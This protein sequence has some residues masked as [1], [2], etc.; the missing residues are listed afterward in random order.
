MH[1]LMFGKVP[2]IQGGVAG[3]TWLACQDIAKAGHSIDVLTNANAMPI[4]FRQMFVLDDEV[5]LQA[6]RERLNLQ[7]ITKVPP[8]SYIPWAPPYF[9]QFMSY[10]LNAVDR[11]RPDVIVGWYL[12]PYGMVA[13]VIGQ[14]FDIPV[15]LRHAGSDIG[16]MRNLGGLKTFYDWALSNAAKVTTGR[17][18]Q[19]MEMLKAAGVREDAIIR[20]R[21]RRLCDSFSEFHEGFDMESALSHSEDW[22][23]RYQLESETLR[24][25]IEWN[26]ASYGNNAPSIGTYGKIAEVKGTYHL[27][28][29]LELLVR[30]GEK[31]SYRGIWSATPAR[32]QHALR[33][34]F[35]KNSLKG[36]I[37][38]LPPLVP[39]RIPAF[40]R[41]CSAVAFL[42]NRF[43]IQI[44][45]PKVPREVLACKRPLL[46]SREIFDKVHFRDQL[47]EE[48]NVMLVDDPH[49]VDVMADQ[50]SRLLNSTELLNCLGHHA[51]ALSR[52]LEARA[53]RVDPIVEVIEAVGDYEH[54]TKAFG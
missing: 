15:I 16:R 11:K 26:R 22:F 19:V 43:P 46:L 1:V 5:R 4:G 30:R 39:W 31:F 18:P 48:K 33:Y 6:E 21:G 20:C 14:M 3:E 10:G 34:L 9:S 50:I 42:E 51:G 37:A 28:D 41:S 44:H 54:R 40:I 8:H 36:L 24:M 12:E 53:L 52:V 2:P 17:S 49:E 25:L 29:A 45:G 47:F 32:L 23:S 35:D 27:L 13:S 38:V 7:N